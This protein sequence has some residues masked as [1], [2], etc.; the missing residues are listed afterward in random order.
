MITIV[1]YNIGNIGSIRNM[2]SKVGAEVQI[3]SSVAEIEQ[4]RKIIL[5]GVGRF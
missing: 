4:A 5:P 2:L 3:A 1:D